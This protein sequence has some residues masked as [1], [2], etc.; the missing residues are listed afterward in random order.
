[1]KH[2]SIDQD[3]PVPSWQAGL[4]LRDDDHADLA[5]EIMNIMEQGILVWSQDGI[6]ELHNTRI[7]DVLEISGDDLTIGTERDEFRDKALSHGQISDEDR[8]NSDARIK[9]HQPYSF[10]LVLPSGRVVLSSARPARGGGYVVTFTDVSEARRVAR[11]LA[12]AKITAEMAESR[13]KD[14]LAIERAR[15]DEAKMLGNLDEWLQSCKSLD[16]LFMIVTKFMDK[17]IPGSAG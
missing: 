17:L 8:A 16:E 6:C 9:A 2:D 10:D 13:A 1:M 4:D 5:T 14:V 3:A 12:N 7:F 15:Q 11:D